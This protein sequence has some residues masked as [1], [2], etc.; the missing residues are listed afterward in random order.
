MFRSCAVEGVLDENRVRRS[1]QLVIERKPRGY[2]GL[3]SQFQR[4]VKLDIARRAARI[5]SA[6]PLSPQS[7]AQFQGDLSRI[8]GNG[9]SFTFSQNPELLGG[10]RVQVGGDVYDGTVQARLDA[11]QESF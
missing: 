2:L 9:L 4:L 1:V 11:L 7:Q 10:V 3:L 5:E 8:Y 6:A